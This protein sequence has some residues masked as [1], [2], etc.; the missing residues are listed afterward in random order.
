MEDRRTSHGVFILVDQVFGDVLHHKLISLLRHPGV[1]E[2]GEVKS[3]R[4]IER[5]LVA[6]ELVCSLRVCTL[7]EVNERRRWQENEGILTFDGSL[8]LGIGSVPYRPPYA[9]SAWCLVELW[10]WPL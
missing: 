6:D 10:T 5:K 9:W 8:Y 1:D 2:R 3:R 4:T 7:R